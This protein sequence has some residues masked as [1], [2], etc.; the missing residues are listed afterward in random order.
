M[1]NEIDYFPR[2]SSATKIDIKSDKPRVNQ[3]DRN[4]L[5]LGTSSKRKRSQHDTQK[6]KE[7]QKKK[8]KKSIEGEDHQGTLYRRLHKQVC[9]NL[10]KEKRFYFIFK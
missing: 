5:F 1:S 7:E 6:I 9:F 3:I 10:N 2:G 4:D 8:K